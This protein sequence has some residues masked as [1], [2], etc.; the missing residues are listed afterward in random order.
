MFHS[1]TV[2]FSV[3][4]FCAVMSGCAA[5]KPVPYAGIESSAM[6]APNT[7]SDSGR[8]PFSY[9]A[10]QTD[11]RGYGRMVLDP[12]TVYRGRD[13]QF[14]DLPDEDKY[15]LAAYM[16][17]EF[18]RALK[19]RYVQVPEADIAPGTLRIRLVLTG[20][21]TNTAVL[22][23]VSRFDLAGGI[24]NGVQAMRGGEGAFTGSVSYAVE[25]YDAASHQ[26]LKSY[27]AKQYPGVY[28]LGAGMGAL[29]AAR[30][31]IEKGAAD[32]LAQMR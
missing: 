28:D 5:T 6:L 26:L 25:I 15:A 17:Q 7:R 3:L 22:S 20:A 30:A 32:L 8:I 27:V 19:T 21:E 31:G 23:T 9:N 24:Y 4:A 12:V 1:K 13:H 18:S 2:S 14:A 11:W 29:S 16:Q 10:P